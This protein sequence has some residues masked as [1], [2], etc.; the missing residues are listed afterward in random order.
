MKTPD[1]YKGPRIQV[2]LKDTKLE[3]SQLKA[4]VD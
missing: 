4:F 2:E 1:N 3:P